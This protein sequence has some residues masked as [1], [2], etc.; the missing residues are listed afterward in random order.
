MRPRPGSWASATFSRV[1]RWARATCCSRCCPC[2]RQRRRWRQWPQA[3]PPKRLH[4]PSAL[5]F[6]SYKRA[7]PSRRMLHGS[8]PSPSATPWACAP[9]A[10]TSPTCATKAALSNTARW[11]WPRKAAAAAPTT[12]CATHRPTAWSPASAASTASAWSSW[13]MTSPCWRARKACATTKRP[14][15]CWAWR[16][17]INCPWCCLPKAAAAARATSMWPSWR[18]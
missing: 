14:T 4:P 8:K 15:A 7:W 10:K 5:T 6:K 2:L 13:P 9:P 1:R 11:P 12:S 18:G 16:C 3:T 17:N